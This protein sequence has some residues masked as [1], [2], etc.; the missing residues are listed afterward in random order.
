MLNFRGGPRPAMGRLAILFVAPLFWACATESS[1]DPDFQNDAHPDPTEEIVSPAPVPDVPSE[2]EAH[3]AVLDT[4]VEFADADGPE[5]APG[6]VAPDAAPE[7]VAE[8]PDP[9][10]IP[11]GVHGTVQDERAPLP[12]FAAVRDSTG[13]AVDREDLL[14]SPTVIWFYPMAETPG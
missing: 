1:E 2:I 5:I 12:E 4:Q 8:S 13:Q 9:I 6:D 10:T 11:E 3:D 14:S 7:E